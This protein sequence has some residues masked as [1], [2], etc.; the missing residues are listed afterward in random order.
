MANITQFPP[1][2]MVIFGAA[3]DLTW[4]KLIPITAAH[5]PGSAKI[6]RMK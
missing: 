6:R 4:R 1:V 3:G 2:E 5:I